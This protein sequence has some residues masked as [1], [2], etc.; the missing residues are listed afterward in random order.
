MR[1]WR[2]RHEAG[3]VPILLL[4]LGLASAGRLRQPDDRPAEGRDLGDHGAVS[5][6]SRHAPPRP[7]AR[8]RAAS[9]RCGASST[10]G[11][12]DDLG[13][14]GPRP[15]ADDDLLRA[16]PRSRRPRWRDGGPARLSPAAELAEPAPGPGQRPPLHA[17]DR[18]WLRGDV[19]LCRP[20]SAARPMG[21]RRLYSAR[22]S[23]PAPPRS[24][25]LPEELRRAIEAQ[26][27]QP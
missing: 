11:A 22:S 23:W 19:Q 27:P 3:A 4:G 5:R 20:G 18:E 1:S 26:E 10:S 25:T 2:C 12:A 17:G 8:S 13:P 14:A 7:T 6:R 16:L 9:R 24:A 15:G 21:D